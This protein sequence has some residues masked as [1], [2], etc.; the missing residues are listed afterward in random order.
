M[1]TCYE[2]AFKQLN[3]KCAWM[4]W[5]EGRANANSS[6]QNHCVSF[7]LEIC[8]YGYIAFK[9]IKKIKKK[10]LKLYT[11]L[12]S[13]TGFPKVKKK[14]TQFHINIKEFLCGRFKHRTSKSSPRETNQN[15]FAVL[16]I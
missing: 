7:V 4:S 10:S 5:R 8:V 16:D 9:W 12:F 2:L 15:P 1:F 11:I 14:N 6:Y 13:F 3:V